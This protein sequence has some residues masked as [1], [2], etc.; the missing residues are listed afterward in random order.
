MKRKLDLDNQ[1]HTA[2]AS[3]F[4]LR[5]FL[6]GKKEEPQINEK[7]KW[8]SVFPFVVRSRLANSRS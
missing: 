5:L 6:R 4:W 2:N 3:P 7:S 1:T 8:A